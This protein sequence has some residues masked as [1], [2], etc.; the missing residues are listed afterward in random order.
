MLEA[1]K[2]AVD[3]GSIPDWISGV[4]TVA[5]FFVAVAVYIGSLRTRKAEQARL[6]YARIENGSGSYAGGSL[7]G[8]G[9]YLTEL[10]NEQPDVVRWDEE[11]ASHVATQDFTTATVFVVN[12]SDEML[13][14]L[15]HV[16]VVGWP[17]GKPWSAENSLR[18]LEPGDTR[19]VKLFSYGV[20]RT[21]LTSPVLVEFTDASGVRWSRRGGQPV[22]QIHWWNRSSHS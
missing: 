5:A 6:V 14:S 15:D 17:E 11:T 9:D 2:T 7:G 10:L 8:G 1:A 4:G 22:R 21:R 12:R 18:P 19:R 20:H 16:A 3:W 13:A